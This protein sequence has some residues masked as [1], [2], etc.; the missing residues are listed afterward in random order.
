MPKNI[1]LNISKWSQFFKY[2]CN[3]ANYH[4]TALPDL[5]TTKVTYGLYKEIDCDHHG[6]DLN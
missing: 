1:A 4:S 2:T 6:A 3:V 5:D